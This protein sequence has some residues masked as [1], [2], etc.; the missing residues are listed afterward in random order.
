MIELLNKSYTFLAKGG[1]LMIP[2]L[3]C[4]VIALAFFFERLWNLQRRKIIPARFL[5]V[6]GDLLKKGKLNEAASLC[7]TNPSPLAAM[8]KA[9]I[10]HAG[11]TRKTIKE[12]ILEA[13]E[14]QLFQMERFV[15]ALGA[16]A[17]I[18]P[19]IGLLGTVTGMI[20]VF[21]GVVSQAASGGAVDA[22]F[23]ANGIW[24]ALL[25]TAAGITVAI[26]TYL[27]HRYVLGKVDAYAVELESICLDL[28][29]ELQ[30]PAQTEPASGDSGATKSGD[31]SGN[32]DE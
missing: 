1:I 14:K 26:P 20:R 27:A 31:D 19:L 21:Q 9:G 12:A 18:S 3:A 30:S 32:S 8:L 22:A 13:G 6:I 15:N 17:T 2:I 29:P 28:T 25:T 7:K 16:I 4:S 10:E 5:E 11:R 23:L 24:E